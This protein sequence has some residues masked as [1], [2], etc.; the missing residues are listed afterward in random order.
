[1]S[2]NQETKSDS[3]VIGTASFETLPTRL[4]NNSTSKLL[5]KRPFTVLLG[6]C[7]FHEEDSGEVSSGYN[8]LW[9]N[10]NLRPHLKFLVGDQVY[11]DQQWINILGTN[12]NSREEVKRDVNK[13][14]F[15]TWNKLYGMLKNGSNYFSSDDHEF[16]NDFPNTPLRAWAALRGSAK[17]RAWVA[18]TTIRFFRNVQSDKPTSQFTIGDDLSFFVADTRIHREK[19]ERGVRLMGDNDLKKLEEW[20]KD[21]KCPGVLVLG[22]PMIWEPYGNVDF[23]GKEFNAIK[24]IMTG[25]GYFAGGAFGAVAG[26]FGTDKV[27]KKNANAIAGGKADHNLQSYEQYTDIANAISRS[28]HDILIL[29]GDIHLGRICKFQIS[30]TNRTDPTNIYEVV[31]S[32]MTVLPKSKPKLETLFLRK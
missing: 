11:V 4:P 27:L 31:S 20:V 1:M 8:E 29:A 6:S 24:G 13:V 23:K 10:S 2:V 12:I 15:N 5:N 25:I 19:Q 9:N 18:T 16:W 3:E 21:L 14:Y 28:K 30:H 17:K 7:F 26:S 32:P 22:Q